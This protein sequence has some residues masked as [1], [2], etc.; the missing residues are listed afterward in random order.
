MILLLL[1]AICASAQVPDDYPADYARAPRFK[2]LVC[3]DAQAGQGIEFF[4]KLNCGDGFVLD[5]TADLSL[6]DYD[7][8]ATYGFVARINT[9]L[10]AEPERRAFGSLIYCLGNGC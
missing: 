6:Y 1:A 4:R 3:Y 10:S 8:F 5:V 7:C 2:A 9:Y